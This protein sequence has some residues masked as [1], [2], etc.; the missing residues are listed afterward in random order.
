MPQV[1]QLPLVNRLSFSTFAR[2]DAPG[3]APS[4]CPSIRSL[5]LG[6][7]NEMSAVHKFWL[8]VDNLTVADVTNESQHAFVGMCRTQFAQCSP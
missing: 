2:A 8:K 7:F 5:Q 4:A 1:K 3:V 6:N